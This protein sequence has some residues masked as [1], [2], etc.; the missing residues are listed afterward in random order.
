MIAETIN[1]DIYAALKKST[2]QQPVEFAELVKRLD[3]WKEA[4]VIIALEAMY[5]SN[6]LGCCMVTKYPRKS[7]PQV[8][9]M[10]WVVGKVEIPAYYKNLQGEHV[11]SGSRA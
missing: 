4:D 9:H 7:E 6:Q 1:S 11:R 2:S 10:W 5:R 8:H 3:G